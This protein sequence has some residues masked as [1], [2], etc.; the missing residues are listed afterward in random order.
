MAE[1]AEEIAKRL[2]RTRVLPSVCPEYCKLNKATLESSK[3]KRYIQYHAGCGR[4]ANGKSS[5]CL[6]LDPQE[7]SSLQKVN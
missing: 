2:T 1:V 6:Q 4:E 3:S 5:K 7:L